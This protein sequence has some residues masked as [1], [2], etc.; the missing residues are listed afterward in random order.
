M[1]FI[2]L[3]F[4][5]FGEHK[6]CFLN[7][8]FYFIKITNYYYYY[9]KTQFICNNNYNNNKELGQVARVLGWAS[10]C[11]ELN[12]SF[13]QSLPQIPTLIWSQNHHVHF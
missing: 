8:T 7:N 12:L 4:L 10:L 13:E 3:I 9:Y 2:Y 5:I 11:H 6:Y 1:L